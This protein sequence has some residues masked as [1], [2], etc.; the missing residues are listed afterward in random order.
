MTTEAHA[1][2]RGELRVS[3]DAEQ[4]AR[5]GAELLVTRAE[6]ALTIR[7]RFRVA[8]SGGQTPR[9]IYELLGGSAFSSRV[10]WERVDVF[11]GDERYVGADDP[12]S[13]YRMTV[14]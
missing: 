9:R 3:R 4:L 14:E 8:L 12:Q 13:N 2:I 6:E 11:F 7:G 5:A 1:R 10:D